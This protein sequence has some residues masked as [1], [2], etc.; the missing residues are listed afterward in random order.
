[1]KKIIAVLSVLAGFVSICNGQNT[2]TL[3]IRSDVETSVN[4]RGTIDGAFQYLYMIDKFNITPKISVT[5]DIS[6]PEYGLVQVYFTGARCSVWALPD[7]KICLNYCD[8]VISFEGSNADGHEYFN[9]HW[10]GTMGFIDPLRNML[11]ETSDYSEIEKKFAVEFV[12]P[13]SKSIDSLLQAGRVS[14]AYVDIIRRDI[15]DY[16]YSSLISTLQQL[17]NNKELTDEQTSQINAVMDSLYNYFANYDDVTSL[18]FN[19]GNDYLRY[20][21][22]HLYQQLSDEKK[23]D[24]LGK[25]I[26]AVLGT[27]VYWLLAPKQV[28]TAWLFATIIADEQYGSMG[29]DPIDAPGILKYMET[30]APESESVR[31]LKK[32]QKEKKQL[33][34][35]KS[36]LS[37]RQYPE[38]CFANPII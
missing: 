32:M 29:F 19:L 26:S 28:Q 10:N 31:I 35:I 1:M 16:E 15:I 14:S 21:Y 33:T 4:I 6:L 25:D 23:N 24:L 27:D 8:G 22:K 11:L 12:E 18:R 5:Y 30:I 17:H 9:K 7:D 36:N 38:V 20:K 13:T 3:Q 2:A 37:D 34:V